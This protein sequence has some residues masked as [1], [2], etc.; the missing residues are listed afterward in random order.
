M[1]KSNGIRPSLLFVSAIKSDI[2]SGEEGGG[3]EGRGEGREDKA[4]SSLIP[5]PWLPAEQQAS[6]TYPL[7]SINHQ[8]VTTCIGGVAHSPRVTW[9]VIVVAPR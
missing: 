6:D 9:R 5:Y 2:T 8:L 7:P 4:L 1:E 3:E